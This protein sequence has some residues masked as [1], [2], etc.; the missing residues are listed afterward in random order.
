MATP[1]D[2]STGPQRPASSKPVSKPHASSAPPRLRQISVSKGG[3][4]QTWLN[5]TKDEVE[6]H[7]HADS[8]SKDRDK[9][10]ETGWSLTGRLR[11]AL[12][13]LIGRT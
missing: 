10:K 2:S 6:K 11:V 4:G 5:L 1:K 7:M 8:K 13:R 9:D 3:P 12:R